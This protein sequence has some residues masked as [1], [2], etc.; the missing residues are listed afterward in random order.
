MEHLRREAT[1]D[2]LDL[3]AQNMKKYN[4]ILVMVSTMLHILKDE[5]DIGSKTI[6]PDVMEARVCYL[7]DTINHFA[8]IITQYQA[9]HE[10][11][12]KKHQVKVIKLV[13]PQTL[14]S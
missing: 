9:W 1:W 12:T 6:Y 7:K 8:D 14:E 3:S 5:L 10:Y 4:G 13:F 11:V 2:D